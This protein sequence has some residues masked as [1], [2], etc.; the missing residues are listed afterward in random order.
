MNNAN[1]YNIGDIL[2]FKKDHPCGSKKWQ[3]LK[4][5]V[6]YKLECCLCRR[7]IIIPRVDLTKKV[8]KK[9]N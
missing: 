5:G 6:D 3:V 2:E 9:V 1:I 7:Q 4:I 8:K